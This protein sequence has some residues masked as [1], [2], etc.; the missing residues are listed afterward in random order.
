[1][2]QVRGSAARTDD[3]LLAAQVRGRCR[4]ASRS[5]WRCRTMARRSISATT[6]ISAGSPRCGS[7]AARFAFFDG[8]RREAAPACGS[9]HA[10]SADRARRELL[11]CTP[12]NLTWLQLLAPTILVFGAHLRVR[13]AAAD[14]ARLGAACRVR[15]GLAGRG[16]YLHWRLFDTVLPARGLGYEIA[17]IWLCFA[18][19]LLAIF[20]QFILYLAFLRATDHTPE[21]D[22]HEARLRAMPPEQL[23]RSTSSSRPTT[24]RSRCWKRPSPARSAS[25][26]PTSRS[27]CSTTAAVP[28]SRTIAREGRGL[29]QPA[30]QQPRQGRQHQSRADQDQRRFRRDIRRRLRAA[31]QFPDAHASASSRSA[32]SASC[33]CRTRSTITIRCRRTWRCRSRCR[34]SSAC[35]SMPSCRAATAGTPRSAA[36]R[37]R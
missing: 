14:G 3:R 23:P 25:T 30:R 11:T 33:R 37:I 1:M 2:R 6:A 29:S 17:W 21:A 26:I 10:G 8:L 9:L 5:R 7:S 16:W 12:I 35:S 20:D 19:E 22:R 24:S 28:G 36:A 31:A 32:R 34:T 4:T 27:G 13:L 15:H 18:V